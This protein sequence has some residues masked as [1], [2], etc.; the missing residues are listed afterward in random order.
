MDIHAAS[1]AAEMLTNINLYVLRLLTNSLPAKKYSS[2]DC[3][4]YTAKNCKKYIGSPI[5]RLLD[6]KTIFHHK[7]SL[8]IVMLFRS[9]F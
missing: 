7:K 8:S 9:S 3:A 1:T 6:D 4:R 2:T 5:S